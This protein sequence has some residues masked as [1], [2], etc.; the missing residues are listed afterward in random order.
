MKL[1]ISIPSPCHE[2]WGAMTPNAQGRH[3]ASC[4]TTV[5]DFTRLSD[6][7]LVARFE[8]GDMPKCARFSKD[9]LDRLLSRP[10]E[11]APNLLAAAAT[12]A[13]LMLVAP[14]LSA[15]QGQA[16]MLG[17]PAIEQVR[18]ESAR[19]R[20]IIA[21]PEAPRAQPPEPAAIVVGRPAF[22][23][24]DESDAPGP[25]DAC[26]GQVITGGLPE[27]RGDVPWSASEID[28]ITGRVIDDLGE[29]LPFASLFWSNGE[30]A[31]SADFDGRFVVRRTPPH[32]PHGLRVLYIGYQPKEIALP[33][34]AACEGKAIMGEVVDGAGRPVPGS[35][36][37][38][39]TLGLSCRT[40]ERGRFAFDLPTMTLAERVHL[41]AT[42]PQG[43]GTAITL[44]DPASIPIC[45]RI[46]LEGDGADER[47]RPQAIDLGDVVIDS[48]PYFLGE[49]VVVEHEGNPAKRR[50]TRP[51]RWLGRQL[52]RPFR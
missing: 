6:A 41:A 52:A 16:I 38:I 7:E 43:R 50:L 14:E 33:T 30:S 46:A 15:Q 1:T 13:A 21:I 37:R 35:L 20:G 18:P 22:S 29:P 49:L 34:P 11:P 51:F 26:T 3:C 25:R 4:A 24:F 31:G 17:E 8:Q 42:D 44:I 47:V 12:G 27:D 10:A 48:E 2:D 9:Q 32:R 36:V 5:A 40:D 23:S 45:L 28:I 39:E 19:L